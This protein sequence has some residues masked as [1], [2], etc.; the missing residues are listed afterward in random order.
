MEIQMMESQGE[1]TRKYHKLLEDVATKDFYKRIDLTNRVNC[2]RCSCGQITKTIDIDAGVTPIFFGCENCGLQAT[3]S[4]YKDIAPNL[5]P[6]IEWYRPKLHEVI[7][8]R[9]KP[10][11]LEHILRGGLDHRKRGQ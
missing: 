10:H 8:M 3:S 6:T 4:M 2:Y 5:K 7:K 1:V 9:S 11:L